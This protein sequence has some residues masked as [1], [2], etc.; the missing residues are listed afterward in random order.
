MPTAAL[1][2][3]TGNPTLKAR[4]GLTFAGYQGFCCGR[5]TLV[6]VRLGVGFGFS[7]SFT[8]L[9]ALTLPLSTAGERTFG[10]LFAV[11]LGKGV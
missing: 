5:Q 11:R 4:S 9:P 3:G 2:V 7:D 1:S 8:A 6:S 10:V